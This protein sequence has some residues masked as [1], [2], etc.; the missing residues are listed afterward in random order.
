MTAK[1][2][3]TF[4]KDEIHRIWDEIGKKLSAISFRWTVGILVTIFLGSTYGSFK[5]NQLM[6][7]D[8]TNEVSGAKVEM[9]TMSN[10]FAGLK[11]ELKHIIRQHDRGNQ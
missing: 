10:E 9:K 8:L 5:M 4:N 11:G 7:S 1:N 6:Y 3:G 2:I